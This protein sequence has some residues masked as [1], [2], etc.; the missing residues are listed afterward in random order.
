MTS[1]NERQ[2]VE[3]IAAAKRAKSDE[4]RDR[5]E[6]EAIAAY[7]QIALR[8]G[9]DQM[10]QERTMRDG[11]NAAGLDSDLTLRDIPRFD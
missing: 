7:R 8:T 11:R 3:A 6:R 2:I 10:L 1:V 5:F 9:L 4:E